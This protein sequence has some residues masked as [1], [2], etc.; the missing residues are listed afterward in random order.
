[1]YKNMKNSRRR[2]QTKRKSR[3]QNLRKYVAGDV[4]RNQI[5]KKILSIGYEFETSSLA[6]LTGIVERNK[7]VGFLN[8]DT[9]R[10]DIAIMTTVKYEPEL[11]ARQVETSGMASEDSRLD[12][13]NYEKQKKIGKMAKAFETNRTSYEKRKNEAKELKLKAYSD[14]ENETEFEDDDVSFFATND[15]AE[16]AIV[17]YLNSICQEELLRIHI[18]A[19]EQA[20][21]E[22]DLGEMKDTIIRIVKKGGSGV[23]QKLETLFKYDET[24]DEEYKIKID[25]FYR[26]ISEIYKQRDIYYKFQRT[27]IEPNPM[28]DIHFETWENTTCGTF[29]DVEWVITY[30][31]PTIS[32]NIVL[33]TFINAIENLTKHLQEY[34]AEM[35]GNL[36]FVV[37]YPELGPIS[38]N[39]TNP[40]ERKIF[41]NPEKSLQRR[42][43]YLQTHMRPNSHRGFTLDDCLVKPQMTFSTQIEDAF[44]VMKYLV[45]D[46]IDNMEGFHEGFVSK[47]RLLENIETCMNELVDKYNESDAPYKLLANDADKERRRYKN[48]LI[49]GIKNYIGLIL[50]KLY[51]YI[52]IYLPIDPGDRTYLKDWLTFNSRHK[53][54]ALYN[55]AK[56]LIKELFHGEQLS[57]DTVIDIIQHLVVDEEILNDYLVDE[58][59]IQSGAYS[60]DKVVKP[61]NDIIGEEY[62][63]PTVSMLSYFQ[64]FE[65]PA[66]EDNLLDENGELVDENAEGEEGNTN[67]N[68]RDWLEYKKVDIYSTQM[69][70]QTYNG[71]R[72][73]ILIEYR[74]FS[75]MLLPY[76]MNMANGDET[77]QENSISSFK[78]LIEL[79]NDDVA[80]PQKGVMKTKRRGKKQTRKR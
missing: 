25:K 48:K 54:Y 2:R 18:T 69:D 42:T 65:N 66:R 5:L 14:V 24:F 34:V 74:G 56:E 16:S 32:N 61:D 35:H 39:I 12:V 1:M 4:I 50:L 37:D 11:F 43:Y 67:F 7:L 79:Y 78:R 3:N 40:E 80:Y 21:D 30:Y 27:D 59:T 45:K 72:N 57:E 46:S 58:G 17:K 6:K 22:S 76:R 20:I 63:D 38:N 26:L 49:S 60:I 75:T 10:E 64:F 55:A 77:I 41:Y 28:Y 47:Y 52:N 23:L 29:A 70:I 62:G 71:R 44:I 51:V 15:I 19:V 8:T 73:K 33:E 31:N 36:Q 13:Y 53:N 9:A 68:Y